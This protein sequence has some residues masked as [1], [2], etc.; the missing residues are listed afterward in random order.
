M[1]HAIAMMFLWCAIIGAVFL[2]LGD[3]AVW[4]VLVGLLGAF[5]GI[6]YLLFQF[7]ET[8]GIALFVPIILGIA[9]LQML[10]DKVGEM[11]LSSVTK[12]LGRIVGRITVS[13]GGKFPTR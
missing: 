4:I 1:L 3:A 5:I 13:L 2:I 8:V 10:S 6:E 12:A 7:K 9:G 11:R